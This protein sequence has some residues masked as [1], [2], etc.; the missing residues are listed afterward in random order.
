MVW[1]RTGK[2][3]KPNRFVDNWVRQKSWRRLWFSVALF[4][5][6]LILLFVRSARTNICVA[7][8][9]AAAW[10]KPSMF[11]RSFTLHACPVITHHHI[12]CVCLLVCTCCEFW[13][14]S[15]LQTTWE[16][17]GLQLEKKRNR[18]KVSD[19]D[20][21][22]TLRWRGWFCSGPTGSDVNRVTASNNLTSHFHPALSSHSS[23]FIHFC[24]M[25]SCKH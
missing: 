10:R 5:A 7:T 8:W 14:C 18:G 25:V 19:P 21:G 11:A 22:R 6:S 9:S 12:L 23:G 3:G 17:C 1:R 15:S 2:Q 24:F 20:R 13:L 16:S 4:A